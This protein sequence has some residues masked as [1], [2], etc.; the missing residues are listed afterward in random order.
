MLA[1]AARRRSSTTSR[2]V[3]AAPRSA[4]R[5]AGSG[6]VS[7]VRREPARG[8]RAGNRALPRQP[9]ARRPERRRAAD[10]ELHVRERAARAALRHSGRLR[11]RFRRVTLPDDRR[12]GL[13]GQASLLT[14]TSYPNRTSPVLRGKW[15]LENILGTPP[16]PPPPDVPALEG[17]GRQRR[18]PVGARA[19]GGAPARTRSARAATR[20]WIRSA[21]RS[22]T[23]TRIGK[24]RTTDEGRT[25]IDA[26]GSLPD[27]AT[28]DGLAGPA[29]RCC[30][31]GASSSSRRS[32]NSC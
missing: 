5:H 22:S 26:S 30:W 10:G 29:D 16:P 18:A 13:L 14:V 2:P 4:E 24:W 3:A 8:L 1:D 11:Q 19:A 25:P 12:G 20:R 23:S 28:F 27:G 9:A 21:S 32:P 7:G 6:S 15:L 31:R 17:Q